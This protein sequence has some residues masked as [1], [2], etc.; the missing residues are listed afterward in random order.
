MFYLAGNQSSRSWQAWILPIAG[1]RLNASFRC[2]L[3][4]NC[5]SIERDSKWRHNTAGAA[6]EE[7][8]PCWW[9]VTAFPCSGLELPASSHVHSG[10]TWEH[11]KS[12][13]SIQTIL[14][15]R[16][17]TYQTLAEMMKCMHKSYKPISHDYHTWF[18]MM[19]I[20]YALYRVRAGRYRL[21]VSQVL[22]YNT[23]RDQQAMM[24]LEL[25]WDKDFWPFIHGNVFHLRLHKVSANERRRYIC[26]ALSHWMRPYPTINRKCAFIKR[27][28]DATKLIVK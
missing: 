24:A 8:T 26:N 16:L 5:L 7:T 25:G 19:L 21:L 14:Q 15:F 11:P 17:W 10:K 2:H 9:P 20:L 1:G 27:C 4:N 12:R 6:I 18:Y 3:C 23:G 13:I 22:G 28:H